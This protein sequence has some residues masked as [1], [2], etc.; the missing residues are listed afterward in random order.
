MENGFQNSKLKFDPI[1]EGYKTDWKTELDI[2]KIPTELKT[3]TKGSKPF[4][5]GL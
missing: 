5:F 2:W 3:V 1:A 4:G